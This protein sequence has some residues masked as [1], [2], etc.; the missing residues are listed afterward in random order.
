MLLLQ[1]FVVMF[2]LQTWVD[3]SLGRSQCSN[4][5]YHKRR[6]LDFAKKKSRSIEKR[7]HFPCTDEAPLSIFGDCGKIICAEDKKNLIPDVWKRLWNTREERSKFGA[8]LL[9]G[10]VGQIHHIKG[11][12]GQ[13]VYLKQR[14]NFRSFKAWMESSSSRSVNEFSAFNA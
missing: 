11:Q 5:K 3:V 13:K 1:P 6:R 14:W 4:F 12:V 10:G 9:L 8:I 7:E 2:V